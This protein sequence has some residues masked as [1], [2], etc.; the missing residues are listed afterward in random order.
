MAESLEERDIR[1]VV[2]ATAVVASIASFI[3]F[4]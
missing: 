4:T 2:V 3:V 1:S